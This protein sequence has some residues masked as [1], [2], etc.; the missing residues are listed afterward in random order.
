MRLYRLSRSRPQPQRQNGE[1]AELS[2]PLG[3][4]I[5]PLS[6]SRHDT[7]FAL[8]SG[9]GRSAVAVVRLSGA[10]ALEVL[11]AIAPGGAFKPREATLRKLRD[12]ISGDV[13]DTALVLTFPA[14]RSFT[15]EAMV[16]LQVT[17]GRAVVRA[18]FEALGNLGLRPAEPGEFAW[19]AFLNGK[20]DLSSVEGLADL[21]EAETHL[22]RRQALRLAGG[23]LRRLADAIRGDLIEASAILAGL[24]DF[25]DVEDADDLSL[26]EVRIVIERAAAGLRAA[27]RGAAAARRV[28]EGFRV[29]VAGPPNAGKST[30]VNA[31]A[32]REVAIVSPQAGTTRDAIEV[33]LDIE[34]FAV[35]LVDTAGLR[36]SDDAIEREGVRRT[37]AHLK[38]A[39]LTLWLQAADQSTPLPSPEQ[40]E[41][42]ALK[43]TTKADLIGDLARD[44]GLLVSASTGEGVAALLAAIAA[45]AR[46]GGGEGASLIAHE[47]HRSAFA[48]SL[49]AL[50]R[51]LDSRQ[52]EPELVA[53]DVRMASQ[54]LQRIAGRIDVEDVLDQVF[55]RL[56]VGK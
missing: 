32:K 15:G 2:P 23:E 14:P 11:T 39:D 55:G 54:A 16:E 18:L 40:A 26:G 41:G 8:A 50:E 29:V 20:L 37:H 45:A 6:S 53:E 48:D 49:K 17:G 43:V 52:S 12:P 21:V 34:G 24:I 22:Q 7:I 51:A 13:L 3:G 46:E 5:M 47:R 35:T 31:L 42:K 9:A 36:D 19:R 30:L 38:D 25:S 27:L 33:L 10:Q 4:E 56:C 44:G 1:A 28:R